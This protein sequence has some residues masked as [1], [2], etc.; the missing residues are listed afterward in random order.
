MQMFRVARH[1]RAQGI[2]TTGAISLALV[3]AGCGSSAQPLTRKQLVAKANAVCSTLHKKM[4]EV[5]PANS[6][7]ELAHVAEKLAGYEQQ[8]I[9]A[10]RKLTPPKQLASD[11]KQM[12]EG[13]EELSES[14]ATLSSALQAKKKKQAEEALKQTA[15]VEKRVTAIAKRDGFTACSELG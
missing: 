3:A 6:P 8:Q 13:A 2:A 5:G 9:E 11:W 12:I 1:N 7:G 14:I 4:K 10:M 15:T